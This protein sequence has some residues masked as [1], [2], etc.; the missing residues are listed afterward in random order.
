MGQVTHQF[1]GG[2]S[3][4]ADKNRTAFVTA[5]GSYDFNIRKRGI[6][7]TRGDV[8]Q[9]QGGAGVS[10]ANRAVELGVAG[11]ALWQVRD[12]RGTRSSAAA[13]SPRPRLR[14]WSRGGSVRRSD[15]LASPRSLCVGF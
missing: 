15:S 7:I 2:G 3:L 12:H 14:T 11:N 8:F 6:D 1:S 13:R 4:F 5:L 9:I 10:R